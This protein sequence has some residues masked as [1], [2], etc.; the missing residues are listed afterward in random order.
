MIWFKG[1]LISVIRP[2][3]YKPSSQFL[4][5]LGKNLEFL[6]RSGLDKITETCLIGDVVKCIWMDDG[7]NGS[8]G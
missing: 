8:V 5:C 1:L 6:G 4:V 3:N 7:S 2:G